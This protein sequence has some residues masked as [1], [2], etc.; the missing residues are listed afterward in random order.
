M[1]R[2]IDDSIDLHLRPM[3]FHT[4][5]FADRVRAFLNGLYALPNSGCSGDI[6]VQM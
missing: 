3:N 4:T 2:F 5:P 6:D 1:K